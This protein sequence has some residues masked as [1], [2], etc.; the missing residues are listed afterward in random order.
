MHPSLYSRLKS[1]GR[2][3][4]HTLRSLTKVW[5]GLWIPWIHLSMPVLGVSFTVANSSTTARLGSMTWALCCIKLNQSRRSRK[6]TTGQ[7]ATSCDRP[8]ASHQPQPPAAFTPLAA[9]RLHTW[10]LNY[11]VLNSCINSKLSLCYYVWRE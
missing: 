9:S 10:R 3:G 1:W 2:R 7:P 5:S 6:A 4:T 11:L 8:A